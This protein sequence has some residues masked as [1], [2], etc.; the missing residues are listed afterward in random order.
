MVC[1]GVHFPEIAE[2]SRLT[3]RSEISD[4]GCM[5]DKREIVFVGHTF[6]F[7]QDSVS[8]HDAQKVPFYFSDGK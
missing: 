3:F 1:Y 8:V 4:S 7:N 2:K 5:L 6:Y